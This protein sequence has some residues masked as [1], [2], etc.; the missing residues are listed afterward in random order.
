MP[1][2]HLL[3]AVART[4][5]SGGNHHL[6]TDRPR[7]WTALTT[8]LILVAGAASA[9]V[10]T[11]GAAHAA[12][13]PISN[14]TKTG[15]DLSNGSTADASTG[16]QGS[17]HSGDTVKWALSYRNK[18]GSDAS[19]SINDPITGA[20]TYVP[21][22]LELPPG[23]TGSVSGNTV[24][25]NG[26]AQSG[27]TAAASPNFTAA[28]VSFSTPGGD[29]YSVEGFGDSIYTVFHHNATDT[30]VFCAT[31]TNQVCAGWPGF[32]S[33]VSPTAGT[34]LGTGPLSGFS[35]A[36]VNGSFISNGR[37]YWPVEQNG[38]PNVFGIQCLDLT[39]RLSCGYNQIG[40]T[41]QPGWGLSGD[42]IAAADGN[43]YYYDSNGFMQCV[44]P[45]GTSCGAFNVGGAVTASNG[46]QEVGTYGRYVFATFLGATGTTD[47]L[48]CFDTATH[49]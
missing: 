12:S 35:S 3:C 8:A 43:Y 7:R 25:A 21:N 44:S 6:V 13:T 19:V 31:L 5:R 48:G 9:S 16:N 4:R 49:T 15:T 38:T 20:Q 26:T 40:T 23:F 41:T 24:T 34:P 45:T 14:F 33:Y 28:A 30:V 32:S 47:N 22:S 2:R 42:G 27:T 46:T 17:A 36:Y 39:T 37:L 29:G 11:S 18:T 1:V 10:V